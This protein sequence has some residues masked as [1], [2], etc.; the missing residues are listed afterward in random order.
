M[1]LLSLNE[2]PETRN[3]P[4]KQVRVLL[5]DDDPA[6][7]VRYVK[8]LER[9]GL[10]VIACDSHLTAL[11]C[12]E[13][14]WLDGVVVNQGVD[15]FAWRAVVDRAARP[16]QRTPVLVMTDCRDIVCQLEAIQLGAVGYLEKPLTGQQVM[17]ALERPR[18]PCLLPNHR[19][20]LRSA[21]ESRPN[22]GQ[23]HSPH[24]G[25]PFGGD[26]QENRDPYD[27]SDGQPLTREV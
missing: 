25:P 22:P 1:S 2:R 8:M 24:D 14:I 21:G 23:E 9:E 11:A 10:S 6:D 19:S 15:R 18:G 12:L 26:G 5:V 17:R 16:G 27:S 3:A 20:T 4:S 7:L 13:A